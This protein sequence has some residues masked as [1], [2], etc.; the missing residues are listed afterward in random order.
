[1]SSALGSLTAAV[2]SFFMI[3]VAGSE[4]STVSA[5]YGVAAI[6][7]LLGVALALGAIVFGIASRR[8]EGTY[9]VAAIAIAL[10]GLIGSSA[11]GAW[12][13]LVTMT[14]NFQF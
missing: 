14:Q 5:L 3:V 6:V 4:T 11:V 13:L 9:W 1:L 2:A 8:N 7:A 12:C 10:V